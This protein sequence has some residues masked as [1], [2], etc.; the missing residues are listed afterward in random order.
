MANG[1]YLLSYLG[2]GG[3]VGSAQSGIGAGRA[4][5]R[6]TRSGAEFDHHR[7]P[8]RETGS[9]RGDEIGVDGN[10]KVKGRK[11]H[12]AVDVLGLV[13]KCHVSA[14]NCADVKVAP[15]VL[16][17]VLEQYGRVSKILADKSYRGDLVTDLATVYG[18]VMEIS[19]R[20]SA[21]TFEV[22]PLRWIVERT[23]AWLD[24]ARSLTRDY[25]RLPEN[26]AGMV[27]VVMIRFM[28][29]RL[30]QNHTRWKAKT[31]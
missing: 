29:R 4:P 11:R 25:E 12:I 2:A 20:V 6:G 21:K 27:Y 8:V 24:N 15:W 7:Q 17:W 13:L 9:K 26:H 5:V 19:E 3:S 28:L 23:W 16:F 14:A 22:E 30:T 10:K 1:L 18:V 31:A